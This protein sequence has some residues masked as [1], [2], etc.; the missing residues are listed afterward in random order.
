MLSINTIKK[1]G[2]RGSAL[3]LIFYSVMTALDL[4]YHGP[5]TKTP[6]WTRIATTDSNSNETITNT[7]QRLTVN[8][9]FKGIN[10]ID[11]N[12]IP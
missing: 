2:F 7:A 6:E 3:I 5:L 9:S 8:E 10:A 1:L 12:R 11:E 4:N